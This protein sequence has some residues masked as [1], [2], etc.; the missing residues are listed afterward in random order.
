MFV[1][2]RRAPAHGSC[3]QWADGKREGRR[4]DGQAGSTDTWF[5]LAHREPPGIVRAG[6]RAGEWRAVVRMPWTAPS[7]AMHSGV[8]R[9]WSRLP[10]R[11]QRR[12]CSVI[13]HHAPASRFIPPA[14]RRRDTWTAQLYRRHEVH[15][16]R[17][18]R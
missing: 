4:N 11:G 15:A 13:A 7:R 14:T 12:P 1:P 17:A 18:R 8:R 10:L 16:N 2:L 3:V 6:L 5:G 9:S